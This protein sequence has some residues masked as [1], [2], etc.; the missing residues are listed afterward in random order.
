MIDSWFTNKYRNDPE[1][2][3]DRQQRALRRYYKKTEGKVKRQPRR[4]IVNGKYECR[5][6]E[7]FKS[8]DQFYPHST[9]GKPQAWCKLCKI[10]HE[11]IARR[12]RKQRKRDAL[13]N[14]AE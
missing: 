7:L 10:S 11:T 3:A 1:F 12:A 2:R 5:K 14:N 9:T 13:S 4:I 8:P 6:C